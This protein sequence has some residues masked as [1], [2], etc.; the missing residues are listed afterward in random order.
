MNKWEKKLELFLKGLEIRNIDKLMKESSNNLN[1]VGTLISERIKENN[2]KIKWK[3]VNVELPEETGRYWCVV[4][5]IN[6]LG[7]SKFQW[8]VAYNVDTKV[9]SDNNK[10]LCVTH[11]N[12]LME[13]PSEK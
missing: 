2:K 12:Q 11:W 13:Y 9:W 8:N 4:K 3:D 1:I 10:T 5:E 7:V 6:S